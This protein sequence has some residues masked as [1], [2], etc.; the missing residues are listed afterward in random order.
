MYVMVEIIA[1]TGSF[2]SAMS[3]KCKKSLK[4]ERMR[5]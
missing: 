2:V 5:L 4:D 3:R 1:Y